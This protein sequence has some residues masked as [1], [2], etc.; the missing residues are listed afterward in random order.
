MP[1]FWK[2][3]NIPFWEGRVLQNSPQK[4]GEF[5]LHSFSH[6]SWFEVPPYAR[7]LRYHLP[8]R[9]PIWLTNYNF[10]AHVQYCITIHYQSCSI[11]KYINVEGPKCD[12]FGRLGISHF[13]Q[14]GTSELRSTKA[15]QMSSWPDVVLLLATRCLY[16]GGTS[17]L[18]STGPN[19]VPVF[20]TRCLYWG[21]H[22]SWVCLTANVK[23]TIHSTALG[24]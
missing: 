16:Q 5:P 1:Q 10:H 4:V 20:A 18:R 21:V 6:L 19:L 22:L 9:T 12:N 17:Q 15:D 3:R 13:E 11:D 24:H 14:A 23:L 8:F 2:I 7:G